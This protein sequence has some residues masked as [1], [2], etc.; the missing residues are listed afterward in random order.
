MK[1][2]T[3]AL[4]N[5]VSVKPQAQDPPAAELVQPMPEKAPLLP[6][7]KPAKHSA[8]FS[9]ARLRKS[10]GAVWRKAGR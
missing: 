2:S 1:N 7:R 8:I 5:E 10:T 4:A 3:L 9:S 6:R